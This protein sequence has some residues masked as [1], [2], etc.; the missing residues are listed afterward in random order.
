MLNDVL[1]LLQDYTFQIVALGTGI[2]GLL[3]GVV[4]SYMTLRQESLLGD[5]LSHA[6]LPGIALAFMIL[7]V[8]VTPVLLLGAMLSGLLAMGL[9]QVITRRTV[10]KLDSVQAMV[11]STFFG[12]GLVLMTAIQRQP[13][14]NQAGLSN[15]IFGQASAMLS[16]DVKLMMGV[17]IAILI[18]IV[19]FWKPFKLITFDPVFAKT[20]YGQTRGYELAMSLMIVLTIMIGLEAVGVILMSALLI[21]PSIAARQWTNRLTY[22]M[23]LSGLIGVTSGVVGTLVSSLASRIP[24]G[25]AIVV[26]LSVFVIISLV[27]APKK[28]LIAKRRQRQRSRQALKRGEVR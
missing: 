6:A 27:A 17:S 28:G 25:P 19:L 21:G 10:L 1:Y 13:N 14:A 12:V 16:D 9:I 18:L 4:G 26:I 11:L 8:K 3:S 23:G 5:T 24:T 7:Q 2:L 20:V 22:V 15:F